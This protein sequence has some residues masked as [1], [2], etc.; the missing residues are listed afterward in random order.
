[1]PGKKSITGM[2]KTGMSKLGHT[3]STPGIG[4]AMG[5]GARQM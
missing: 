3:L 5:F 2:K 4:Y 1:M